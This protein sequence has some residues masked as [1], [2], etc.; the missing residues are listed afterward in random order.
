MFAF[1]RRARKATATFIALMSILFVAA[2][3]GGLPTIGGGGPQIDTSKP[4]PV[5]LLVPG[6]SS[7]ANDNALAASLENSARLAMSELQGVAI[8]LRVYNTAGN[9]GQASSQAQKAIADGAK[10][11][12]GPVYAQNA[13]SAGVAAASRG[14]NVLAFSNNPDVAGG[15]VFILGNTFENTARR[16]VSYAARQGKGNIMILYGDSPAETLARDSI[17]RAI[18]STSGATQ[19]GAVGFELSQNGIVQAMPQISSSVKSSGANSIFFTSGTD[20]A[21]PFVTGL[22]PDN[23]VRSSDVQFAGIQRWD[24]PANALTLPGVQGGWFALPDPDLSTRFRQRYEAAY[25][26]P[27][28]PIAGLAY[29][30]VAAIGALV[31]AGKADAL[32]GNALTQSQGFVGVSGVFRLRNDGTNDRGLAIAQVQNQKVVVID[33]A[34]KSFGGVGF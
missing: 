32:T 8:D 12:L 19:A 5:A 13:A 29:D 20:G 26:A 34:P 10:V 15:N 30:G 33:P 31:K 14:V 22:L 7:S 23:G 17:A 25:G 9:A 28:H 27:P 16:M 1:L 4:V 3:G 21:L 6:G 11:I 24:I 18:A 2:C